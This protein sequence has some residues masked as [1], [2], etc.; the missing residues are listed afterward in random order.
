MSKE[1]DNRKV[2]DIFLAMGAVKSDGGNKSLLDTCDVNLSDKNKEK[3][4]DLK[5]LEEKKTEESNQFVNAYAD[6][7][8]LKVNTEKKVIK[9]EDKVRQAGAPLSE[10]YMKELLK[11]LKKKR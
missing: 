9:E 4:K 10:D 1:D 11:G 2:E 3:L 8:D 7:F 5:Q 6:M